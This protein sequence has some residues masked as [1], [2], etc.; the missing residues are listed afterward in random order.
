M[1]SRAPSGRALDQRRRLD[2]DEPVGVVDLTDR[3]DH[4]AAEHEPALHRLAPDVEIA[5]LEPDALVD[6]GVRLVELESWCSC[7]DRTS[8]SVAW[9]SMA[10]VGSLVFSVP[11]WRRTT[12][13]ATDT[14]NSGRYPGG[15]LMGGRSVGLVDDDLGDPV[16]VAEVQE[17]EWSVIP[18]SVD[19]AREPGGERPC[20]LLGSGRSVRPVGRGQ[21][22]G[23][24]RSWRRYRIRRAAATSGPSRSTR[25]PDDARSLTLAPTRH[26]RCRHRSVACLVR[27]R[28]RLHAVRGASG[29]ILYKTS[30]GSV[31]AI[32][33]GSALSSGTT[34]RDGLHR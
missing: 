30:V 5:V 26:C 7:S 16:A 34:Y 28:A 23:W 4:P 2:L 32:S 9:S 10:P 18:A 21:G 31:F 27:G 25:G 24:V 8:T 15:S 1:N 20:W 33:R 17:D 14:T 12:G 3:L 13:P 19:P 6:P 11:G 29:A 22:S